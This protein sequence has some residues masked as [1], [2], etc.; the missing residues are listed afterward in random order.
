MWK[1]KKKRAQLTVK[2][3]ADLVKPLPKQPKEHGALT[4]FNESQLN[5]FA[6]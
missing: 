4:R 5:N 3:Q 1:E 6:N 2:F